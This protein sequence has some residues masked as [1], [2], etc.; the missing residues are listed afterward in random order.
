[1]NT[2]TIMKTVPYSE[3]RDGLKQYKATANNDGGN[4]IMDKQIADLTE[5]Y[6]GCQV[7]FDGNDEVEA[8]YASIDKFSRDTDDTIIVTLEDMEGY[9]FDVDWDEVKNNEFD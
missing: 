2:N 7:D 5:E 4:G 3:L 1:M 9:F 8:F 6:V